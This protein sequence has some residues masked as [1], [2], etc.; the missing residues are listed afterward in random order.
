MSSAKQEE[1][2]ALLEPLHDRLNRF[3]RAMNY[4]REEAKDIISETLLSAYESFDKLRNRDT[5]LSYLFTIAYRTNIKCMRRK[6]LS[7]FFNSDKINEIPIKF[8]PDRNLEVEQLYKALDK[9]PARQKQSIILFE[10]SGFTIEEISGIQGVTVSGVKSRLKRGREK[11][12]EI[13]LADEKFIFLGKILDNQNDFKP[14]YNSINDNN[15]IN[16]QV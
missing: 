5:F 12:A 3:V 10:I 13:L 7:D 14:V 1:F 15:V 6:K 8:D 4:D 2:M 9:L 11:L 16:Y